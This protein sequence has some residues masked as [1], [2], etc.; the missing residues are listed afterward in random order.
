MSDSDRSLEILITTKADLAGAKEAE[1]QL[2]Q[3]AAKAKELGAAY[4]EL[5]GKMTDA[6]ADTDTNRGESTLRDAS[7]L[8][9]EVASGPAASTPVMAGKTVFDGSDG[10]DGSRMKALPTGID[11]DDGL[12]RLIAGIEGLR[13]AVERLSAFFG[14][15]KNAKPSS[16]EGEDAV[17]TKDSYEFLSRGSERQIAA[18]GL[19]ETEKQESEFFSGRDESHVFDSHGDAQAQAIQSSGDAMRAAL[20]QGT[21]ITLEMFNRTLDLVEEQNRWL[22]DVD[23]RITELSGQI[24]SLKNL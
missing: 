8:K 1:A 14:A 2:D 5:G 11:K 17:S 9:S 24:K 7:G 4:D 12:G 21:R 22:G 10:A 13:L 23:R 6:A 18:D 15:A 19:P 3:D 20:E 16:E